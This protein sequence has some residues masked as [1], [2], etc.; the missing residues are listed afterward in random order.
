VL[1]QDFTIPSKFDKRGRPLIKERVISYASRSNRN[2]E[3][4]YGATQLEQLAVVWAVEHYRHYLWGR[5]FEVITDHQ[6]LKSLMKM[7]DPKGIYARWIMRLRPYD[8]D[9]IYKPGCKHGHA[10]ALSRRP[11]VTFKEHL[12][13]GDAALEEAY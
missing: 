13:Q 11:L 7:K 4:N 5:P 8:I 3:R 1:T 9:M 6:A 10:D 2:G 12:P